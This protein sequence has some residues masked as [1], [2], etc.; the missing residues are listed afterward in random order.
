MQ[1][2]NIEPYIAKLAGIW[3]K[4]FLGYLAGEIMETSELKTEIGNL[5]ARIE[6][7]REWL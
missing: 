1:K 6:N 3:Y 7:I 4:A 5:A 2:G